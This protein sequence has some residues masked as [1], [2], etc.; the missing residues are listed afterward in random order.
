MAFPREDDVTKDS[1]E[2]FEVTFFIPGPA[3]VDGVQAGSINVMIGLS[4]GKFINR[5]Y[6][7]ISRLNDDVIGQAHLANLISLRDYIR[8]RLNDEV[9]PL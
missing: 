1:I 6:N 2:D 8:T 7:L 9:L 4:D 3:N 5:S